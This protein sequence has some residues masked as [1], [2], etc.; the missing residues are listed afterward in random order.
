MKSDAQVLTE[1]ALGEFHF[2]LGG[3]QVWTISELEELASWMRLPNAEREAQPRSLTYPVQLAIGSVYHRLQ[4]LNR[5]MRKLNRMDEV[6][7]LWF[8][9]FDDLADLERTVGSL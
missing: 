7:A 1:V 6:R 5:R 2:H 8:A 9:G 3:K 4:R